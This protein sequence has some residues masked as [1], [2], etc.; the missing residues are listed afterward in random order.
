[1]YRLPVGEPYQ[2]ILSALTKLSAQIK[3]HARLTIYWQRFLEFAKE[4][5]F[6]DATAR[7]SRSGVMQGS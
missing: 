6:L 1:M 7:A 5:D 3:N 4:N 2:R